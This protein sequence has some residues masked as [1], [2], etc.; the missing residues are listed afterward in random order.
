[1]LIRSTL[2]VGAALAVLAPVSAMACA[3]GCGIFDT[4]VTSIT[5]QSSDSGLSVF[6]R[7]TFMDQDRNREA[8]HA[9]SPDD[10]TD[11]RIDSQFYTVGFNYKISPKWMIM[12]ELPLVHR[13]F[14]TIP[15]GGSAVE[16]VPLTALGDAVIN[17][18]Y[19]GFAAD[20]STGLGFGIKLP[21]GRSTSPLDANGDEAY[22]RDTLPGTGSTDLQVTGYH[23]GTIAGP[24]RW[25]AHAQFRFAVATR[26]GYR[27]GDEANGSLGVTYD[28][29]AGKTTLSPTLQLIGSLRG[30]D[31]G[32]EADN[33]NSGYQRLL[34]APGLRVQ[35]TRKLSVYGDVEFPLAQ[36]VNSASSVDIEGKSGQLVAPVQFKL[37]LDYGF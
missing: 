22:D 26:D 24:A 29:P 32:D 1:M 34:L 14:T 30:R 9:A 23:V 18:T 27:P 31:T 36:Y 8:G 5:P 7:T 37:Q 6:F 28:L 3:C 21:T 13:D 10:N 20:G 33:L 4:G 17:L 19:T 25:F 12:A 16:T 35:V 15:D 11:K 2:R